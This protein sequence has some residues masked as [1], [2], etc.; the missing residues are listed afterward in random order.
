MQRK[1]AGRRLVAGLRKPRQAPEEGLEGP[2]CSL[3]PAPAPLGCCLSSELE[4]GAWPVSE[5]QPRSGG[6][7]PEAAGSGGSPRPSHGAR[8]APHRPVV[9]SCGSRFKSGPQS[10]A[11]LSPPAPSIHILRPIPDGCVAS[12]PPPPG[13]PG[14][15]ILAKPSGGSTAPPW[16]HFPPCAWPRVLLGSGAA[17]DASLGWRRVQRCALSDLGS[18]PGRHFWAVLCPTAAPA[19][20]SS[21]VKGGF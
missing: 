7:V 21:A 17:A 4:W 1:T 15:L 5:V 12:T 19:P 11:S 18:N 6:W 2:L 10:V 9:S 13:G 14:P 16:T 3:L 20:V 8:P